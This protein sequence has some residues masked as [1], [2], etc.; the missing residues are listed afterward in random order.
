[1]LLLFFILFYFI[2]L[3]IF[4][5]LVL[6]HVIVELSGRSSFLYFSLW[7]WSSNWLIRSLLITLLLL[8]GTLDLMNFIL[9]ID[10]GSK[11]A[12]DAFFEFLLL[13]L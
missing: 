2:D 5:F 11:S 13:V 10:F 12:F 9:S 4:L 8:W 1:L 3:L 7:A 6:H